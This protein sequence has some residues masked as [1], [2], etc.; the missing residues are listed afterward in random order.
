MASSIEQAVVPLSV[1]VGHLVGAHKER[2]LVGD[3]R[4]GYRPLPSSS[5][6]FHGPLDA[7]QFF[8][9]G[10][11]TGTRC[12]AHGG[13]RYLIM[14]KMGMW[15]WT[16]S[17]RDVW[18]LCCT[19]ASGPECLWC[20]S[21]HW[22]LPSLPWSISRC[23]AVLLLLWRWHFGDQVPTL[24]QRHRSPQRLWKETFVRWEQRW[25]ICT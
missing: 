1:E 2:Y 5:L 10:W 7:Y 24:C 17:Q 11:V 4:I 23:F 8:V 16:K 21:P 3:R 19:T 12:Y 9:A 13:G 20:R 6:R 22:S 14:A 18:G 15:T 25:Y